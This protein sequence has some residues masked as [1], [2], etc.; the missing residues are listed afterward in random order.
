MK[1]TLVIYDRIEQY[2]QVLDHML[3]LIEVQAGRRVRYPDMALVEF[4]SAM[5]DACI[6]LNCKFDGGPQPKN[7]EI[8]AVR[9]QAARAVKSFKTRRPRRPG[10][11]EVPL[12]N[13]R[14]TEQFLQVA[15]DVKMET[16]EALPKTAS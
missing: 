8:A 5:A 12:E 13:E 1:N 10:P 16:A 15:G 11:V 7:F 6:M 4:L 2:I 3:G 14:D 9:Q